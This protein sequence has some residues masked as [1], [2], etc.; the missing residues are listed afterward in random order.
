MI[1]TD[2]QRKA[3]CIINSWLKSKN[4]PSAEKETLNSN[5]NDYR[6]KLT[7]GKTRL[8][9][10]TF[11]INIDEILSRDNAIAQ[12]AMNVIFKALRGTKETFTRVSETPVAYYQNDYEGVY[13][14]H[15]DFNRAPNVSNEEISE[16][17][18]IVKSEARK[19][20]NK[21]HRLATQAGFE[22]DDLYNIGLV[23]LISF[24]HEHKRETLTDTRGILRVC[25]KQRYNHWAKTTLIK[26]KNAMCAG[27]FISEA[28][29][30]HFNSEIKFQNEIRSE[31]NEIVLP[32]YENRSFKIRIGNTPLKLNIRVK[33][34]QPTFRIGGQTFERDVLVK[35][36]EDKVLTPR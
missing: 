26:H 25:L 19:V 14:R 33:H 35:L 23:Y 15:T 30:N 17:S 18:G 11:Y 31:E 29:H 1:D 10:K 6:F 36:I 34:G 9:C 5:P 7:N 32:E 8:D 12:E 22:Y 13:L 27:M 2:K 3:L 16:Y 4:I 28:D 20:F 24:L 21:F